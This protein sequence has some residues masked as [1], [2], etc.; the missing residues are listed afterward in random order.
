MI[1]YQVYDFNLLISLITTSI[2]DVRFFTNSSL[3]PKSTINF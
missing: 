2:I 3:N 1:L